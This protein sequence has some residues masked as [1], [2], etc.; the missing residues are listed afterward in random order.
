M[1][2]RSR[3]DPTPVFVVLLCAG[4]AVAA[5]CSIAPRNSDAADRAAIDRIRQAFEAGEN[6][7]D[8][9]SLRQYLADDAIGMAPNAPPCRGVD[10]CMAALRGWFELFEVDV[11]YRSEEIV[12]AGN[13]AFDRGTAKEILAP[14]KGG[15][16]FGGEGKY[17]WLYRRVGGEWKQA[18]AIWNSSEPGP[19]AGAQ[20]SP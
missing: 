15:A 18:R 16:P 14:K 6:A 5:A 11:Q 13:W 12:I 7:G 3:A 10:A 4:A 19:E 1:R 20:S 17:L 8:A 2:T 9:E